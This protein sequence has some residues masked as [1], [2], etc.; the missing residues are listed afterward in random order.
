[1]TTAWMQRRYYRFAC[2]KPSASM[3][4]FCIHRHSYR[5]MLSFKCECALVVRYNYAQNMTK[6]YR[7]NTY[8]S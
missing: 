1:M 8:D 4:T 3:P 5:L 2:L 6:S 7:N